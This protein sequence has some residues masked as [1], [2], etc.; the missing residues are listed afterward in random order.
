M[1]VM[2]KKFMRKKNMNSTTGKKR[3][4]SVAA[5]LMAGA[6][7]LCGCAFKDL[8]SAGREEESSTTDL[9]AMDTVM[10][11]TAYGRNS[12]AA[13]DAAVEEIERLD[14]LLSTGDENSEITRLNESG[15][16]VL[17]ETSAELMERSIE[18]YQST[19]GLFDVAIYPLMDLWG[20]TNQQYRV[21]DEG[22]LVE[23]IALSDPALINYSAEDRMI[24]FSEP[25]MAIDFGGIAKGYTS[26]RIMEI[27]REHGIESGI[28]N[29]G[30]NIH[31][32]GSKT[33]GS[34]WR[35]AVKDPKN[36]G[37]FMGVLEARDC[38]MITSG[39]YERFFEEDGISY[40]HIIDPRTGYPANSG[41]ASVTI[42]SQD[43]TLA[44]A[45]S[46]AL[47]IMGLDEATEYWR[48]H[49]EEF[50]F[51]IFDGETI[52]ITEGIFDQFSDASYPVK[53]VEIS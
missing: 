7:F 19:N 44:D 20:F 2:L 32:L 18:F 37:S 25:G 35:I 50:D 27:F 1:T 16:A 33:D 26:A 24:S 29:L 47:F 52:Y 17:S 43:G 9:L 12:D 36:D 39:G 5:V 42:V 6:L 3:A 45:L 49:F 28:V 48:E 30:G 38:A 15:E 10:T 51:I 14:A 53:R 22:E 31:V 41:L 11:V 46:T 13:V 34:A 21:P 40:H 23:A 4:T 8:L